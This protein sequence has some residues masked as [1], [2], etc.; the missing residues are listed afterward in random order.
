MI[1][2]VSQARQ[3]LLPAHARPARLLHPQRYAIISASRARSA[4]CRPSGRP[5]AANSAPARIR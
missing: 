1:D 4:A 5:G 2:A 3:A